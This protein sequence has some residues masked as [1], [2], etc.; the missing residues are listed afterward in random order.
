MVRYS[1]VSRASALANSALVALLTTMLAL[2][3]TPSWGIARVVVLLAL[4]YPLFRG[5]VFA[6]QRPPS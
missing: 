3:A 2:S 6:S 5:W 1:I 4:T